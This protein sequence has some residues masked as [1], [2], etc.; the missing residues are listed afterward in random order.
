MENIGILADIAAAK[1][2][3]FGMLTAC[4]VAWIGSKLH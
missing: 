2:Q 1:E 3:T 4:S